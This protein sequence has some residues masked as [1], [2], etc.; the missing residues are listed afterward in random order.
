MRSWIV[1]TLAKRPYSGAVLASECTRSTPAR[2]ARRGRC[3]CSPRTRWARLV[4]RT[5]TTT[6]L[7]QLPERIA[8]R[9]SRFTNAVKRV[10]GGA[11]ASSAGSS[12]RAATSMPPV[13]P[14]HE[15]DEVEAD[16]H[17]ARSRAAIARR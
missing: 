2:R 12:S 11:A 14:G 9:A 10:P 1:T 7:D 13:S 17:Q 6:S 4:A 16:V 5:G 8:R 3:C 15:E